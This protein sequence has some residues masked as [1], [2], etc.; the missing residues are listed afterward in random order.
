VAARESRAALTKL[1]EDSS[2][3]AAAA[4]AGAVRE[5]ALSAERLGALRHANGVLD[6]RLRSLL[7]SKLKDSSKATT[8][9]EAVQMLTD[10]YVVVVDQLR[11]SQSSL[12]AEQRR[13][14]ELEAGQAEVTDTSVRALEE[15]RAAEVALAAMASEVRE[16]DSA[17]VPQLSAQAVDAAELRL[18]LAEIQRADGQR[19]AAAAHRVQS[20]EASLSRAAQQKTSQEEEIALLKRRLNQSIKKTRELQAIIDDANNRHWTPVG[21]SSPAA[22]AGGGGGGGRG[23]RP[24]ALCSSP[25][26]PPTPGAARGGSARSG[27]G[28][29]GGLGG[30]S[31]AVGGGDDAAALSP[32]LGGEGGGAAEQVH[33]SP[34]AFTPVAFVA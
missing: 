27:G 12:A 31:S 11:S 26:A 28:G 16:V 2:A 1:R 8:L 4:E 25:S 6:G 5:A 33:P 19:T 20:A 9:Q 17:L 34:R 22:G 29:G 24:L 18:Q 23:G 30:G 13:V 15:R 21:V 32:E 14:A 10:E 7:D 3:Q